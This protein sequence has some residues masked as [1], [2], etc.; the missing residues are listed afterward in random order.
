MNALIRV[1]RV[2]L[3]GLA[4]VGGSSAAPN[5]RAQTAAAEET[6]RSVRRMLDCRTT[7][8]STS[9]CFAS[10]EALCIW[11]ATATR[12]ISRPTLKGR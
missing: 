9:S 1:L 8:S 10:I 12:A 11:L 3:I 5:T 7:A 4:L 2:S 6:A